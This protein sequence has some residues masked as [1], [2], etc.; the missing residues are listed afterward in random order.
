MKTGQVSSG[1]WNRSFI[2]QVGAKEKYV[3]YMIF[4]ADLKFGISSFLSKVGW[5]IFNSPMFFR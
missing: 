4:Q 3:E 2:P 1:L 5:H